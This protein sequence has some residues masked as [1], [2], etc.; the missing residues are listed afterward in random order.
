V[1]EDATATAMGRGSARPSPARPRR[2]QLV[3]ETLADQFV[4]DLREIW[5]CIQH[6]RTHFDACVEWKKYKFIFYIN[7][8]KNR[9]IQ[10]P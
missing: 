3:A 5:Q 1:Q 7:K 2:S 6:E 8:Q 10:H 9:R 4:L